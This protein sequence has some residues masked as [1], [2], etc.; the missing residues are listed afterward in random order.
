MAGALRFDYRIAY[1]LPP[2]VMLAISGFI[3]RRKVG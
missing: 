2:I 3:F 1:A